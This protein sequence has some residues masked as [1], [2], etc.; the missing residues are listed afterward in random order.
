M[1]GHLPNVSMESDRA[2][3]PILP[4]V[5]FVSHPRLIEEHHV[6]RA[7]G[8]RSGSIS[9]LTRPLGLDDFAPGGGV[10]FAVIVADQSGDLGDGFSSMYS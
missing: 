8:P 10:G 2:D 9:S 4:G 6:Q 1:V 5:Q 3:V 7:S